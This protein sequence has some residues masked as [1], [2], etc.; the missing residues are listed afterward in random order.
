MLRSK[1]LIII[2]PGLL[3][4]SSCAYLPFSQP[5]KSNY[6]VEAAQAVAGKPF[7]YDEYTTALATYVNDSGMVNYEQLQQNRQGLDRFNAL[8]ANVTPE[9]FQSWSEAEQLA[10]WMNAYNS[11]TLQAI[12]DQEPLKKSIRDITGLWQFRKFEIAQGEKTLDNIEHDT[13]RVD[14]NEPRIHAALVCAAMSCPPL[15]NEP[16]RAENLEEQLEDQVQTF[17]YN[18]ETGFKIDR[19]E[20]KVYLSKIFDWYGD[21][22]KRDYSIEGKFAG[23]EKERAVLNFISNYLEPEDEAYLEQGG[24]KIGYLDYDWALNKQ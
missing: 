4:L 12:I 10:F 15:R 20:N 16:F 17:V 6:S 22:W 5:E 9:V 24:Y 23:N 1:S 8:L 3:L 14:F 7:S 11:F 21:D 18:P 2:F 19:Q 13:I